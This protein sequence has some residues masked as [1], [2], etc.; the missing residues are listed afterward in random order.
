MENVDLLAQANI[1]QVSGTFGESL[2]G[3]VLVGGSQDE[4]TARKNI[5]D[6]QLLDT[7]KS[8][9]LAIY[10][11]EETSAGYSYMEFYQKQRLTATVDNID[12]VPGQLALVLSIDGKPGHYGVKSTAQRLLPELKISQGV[13]GGA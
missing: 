13:D 3:I 11:V 8:H 9:E 1:V 7:F 2:D 6:L 5:L 12:T 10:G 4:D